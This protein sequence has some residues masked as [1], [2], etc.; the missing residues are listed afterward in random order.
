MA[1]NVGTQLIEMGVK[2][3]IIS[4]WAVD[5]AAAKTFSETFYNKM[6][7]GHDFGTAVQ[8]A[9]LNC[10]Q[11][12][13]ASN[14]W[15]AYQCY[16]NQFYRLNTR[17]KPAGNDLEYVISSQVY[18]DLDNLMIAIRDRKY[19]TTKALIKLERYLEKVD[20]ANLLDAMVLEKEAMVYNELGKTE[21]ALQKFKDLF[22][23][24]SGN[25]SIGALEQFCIIKTNNIKEETILDDLRDIEFLILIG[26]NPSRLNIVANA[27]KLASTI[28]KSS[29]DQK[30]Y[31][32][33]AFSMYEES[34]KISTDKYDGNALDAM[35]NLIFI[36]HILELLG[37][38]KLL[39][40]MNDSTAF[41]N[42]VDVK[43]FLQ[44]F[45]QELEDYDKTDLDISVLIGM[46]EANY[47]LMLLNSEFNPHLEMHIIDRFKHVFQ[48]LYSPR[49]V[50]YEIVQ[51]DFL[52][53]YIK[54][55]TIRGQ[56][57]KIKTEITGLL[58]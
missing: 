15:G 8:K 9:R 14:T 13:R 19:N 56:L 18:T 2:A 44:D 53:C 36:G 41:E 49:Y 55:E 6:F 27:Y 46:A 45:H 43:T 51:I 4:G 42:V 48:L 5:D 58:N 39:V 52:L 29:E 54:D 31:L 10:Y 17:V 24:T 57:E 33:K 28:L 38:T 16:G 21:I 12:H 30:F 20:E 50:K 25:F 1:A 23:Y 37:D 40:R 34:Y 26:K 47:G 22:L 32:K 11:S 3:I 35:S 7:E